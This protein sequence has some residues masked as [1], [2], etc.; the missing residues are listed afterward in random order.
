LLDQPNKANLR[1]ITADRNGA[2]PIA[3][4]GM[5]RNK[6]I[7][8]FSK[9]PGSEPVAGSSSVSV[10]WYPHPRCGPGNILH[11]D[12][13]SLDLPDQFPDQ[14]GADAVVL[15]GDLC[16]AAAAFQTADAGIRNGQHHRIGAP[17]QGNTDFRTVLN[18]RAMAPL[19]ADAMQGADLLT[20]LM[21]RTHLAGVLLEAD[22]RI[23]D[24][25]S[26]L[27]KHRLS[28]E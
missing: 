14:G 28:E 2:Y 10:G 3:V 11:Q 19:Y 22:Q 15:R 20:L 5:K 8:C 25:I 16:Q 7:R 18:L 6:R 4:V 23:V 26:D 27:I 9:L 13:F 1:T 24:G 17:L 12:E 21:I